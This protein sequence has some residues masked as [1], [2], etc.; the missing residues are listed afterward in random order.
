MSVIAVAGCAEGDID[1]YEPLKTGGTG[2]GVACVAAN[3]ATEFT[4]G[5]NV[6][7]YGGRKPLTITSV[8]LATGT[9]FRVA[10]AFLVPV[11]SE[12]VGSRA[13]WPPPDY[14]RVL[15]GAIPAEGAQLSRHGTTA[16]NLVVHLTRTGNGSVEPGL[17]RL[18]YTVGGHD[19]GSVTPVGL[20]AVTATGK[21]P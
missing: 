17:V 15:S 19:Y 5:S 21:C 2:D 18:F 16:Y 20:Q 1:D 8:D 3:G 14:S 12:L 7:Q 13:Q 11:R 4:N 6:I 10:E 9:G